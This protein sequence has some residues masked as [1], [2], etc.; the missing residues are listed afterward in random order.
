MGGWCVV[1]RL[2]GRVIRFDGVRGYGFITPDSGGDDVFLHANDLEMEKSAAR[3]GARV[4]FAVEHGERGQ[5]ATTVRLSPASEDEPGQMPAPG[6]GDSSSDDYF[7]V[8]SP[9]E[10]RHAVTE[11]LLTVTPP[12]TAPQIVAV[13][14]AFAEMADKQGWLDG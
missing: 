10:F 7:D 2:T 4:S 12:L 14:A 9:A 1:V 13:R 3:P 6:G 8:L 11:F 5:F